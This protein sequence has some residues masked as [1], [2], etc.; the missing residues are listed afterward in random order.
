M[1]SKLDLLASVL[2]R[3][4]VSHHI[5]KVKKQVDIMKSSGNKGMIV[6]YFVGAALS[7]IFLIFLNMKFNFHSFYLYLLPITAFSYGINKLVGSAGA[8]K[9][10]KV[11]RPEGILLVAKNGGIKEILPEVIKNIKIFIDVE[12]PSGLEAD[13]LLQTN[14]EE[15]HLLFRLSENNKRY[16]EN[17]ANTIKEVL[18]LILGLEPSKRSIPNKILENKKA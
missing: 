16:L 15:E 1:D 14:T 13:I 2:K 9:F 5:D 11:I 12:D 6:F 18:E 7:L 4:R 10:K 8:N 3:H 17:D